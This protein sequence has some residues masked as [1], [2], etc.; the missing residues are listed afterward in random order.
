MATVK[1]DFERAVAILRFGGV[2]GFPTETV[3]GL[4][5]RA[6]DK[7]AVACVY[8]L[9][10]RPANNPLIVHVNGLAQ[11]K[12]VA[13]RV[14][15]MAQKLI[16][17]FWPGPLTLI[18]EKSAR[19]P[20]GVTSGLDTVAVRMPN[21]PLALKLLK[22][23][24][25]PIAAPSAN[26]SGRPSPTTAMHVRE[27][28]G[29]DLEIVLDGGPC[30]VGLESTIVD[31]TG[32]I[33]RILRPGAITEQQLKSVAGLSLAHDSQPMT[34]NSFPP[35]PGARHR[36]YAPRCR[37]VLFDRFSISIN[38]HPLLLGEGGKKVGILCRSVLQR[39]KNSV[40]FRRIPGPLSRYA[41]ALFGA[42]R[43]A[44]AAGVKT[45]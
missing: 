26:R 41:R 20:K 4:G 28:F 21:H 16:Q 29:G 40:Y 30:H 2:V 34:L 38:P 13:S 27:E 39:P 45:L 3:Y 33:L 25:E 35:C 18:L 12:E 31:A 36:H 43:E 42:V 14:P 23:L 5:A 1:T 37:V 44:E 9:K 17:A 11:L 19:I 22:E 8:R 6:F 32:P 24:G 15:P 7:K 10:G